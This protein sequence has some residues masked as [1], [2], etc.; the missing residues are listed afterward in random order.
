MEKLNDDVNFLY[1]VFVEP[2]VIEVERV[3]VF[4]Q[5][6]KADPEQ[7][8]KELDLLHR[9][10]K[11]RVKDSFGQVLA[12]SRVDFGG[13]FT[14]E[15][16]RLVRET[17]QKEKRSGEA[18]QEKIEDYLKPRALAFLQTLLVQLEKR[19]P[20][21]Q[22][23]F[24]GLSLLNPQKVLS[25][26]GRATF[27]ELPLR[28]LIDDMGAV[29]T[30]YRKIQ[31]QIWR[32]EAVFNGDLPKESEPFWAKIRKHQL[33]DGSFPYR[34]LSN[35]ALAALS[36]PV[37]NAIVERVFSHVTFVKNKNRSRLNL[38]MLDS[39]IRV[40]LSLRLKGICCTGLT[41]TPAM[42]NK[43]NITMYK[44][45]NNVDDDENDADVVEEL[46]VVDDLQ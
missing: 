20:P 27:Q 34:E 44:K 6:L 39:I 7:M 14:T 15:C 23:Q 12:L 46:Y 9:S 29:D 1:F 32:E 36:V 41:V 4:F 42:L 31:L 22:K 24:N 5:T 35:Y 26:S 28:H 19:L 25:Q 38:P 18:L 10:I 17:G 37:S 8:C 30:Q 3:N 43:F 33:S 16:M 40:R 45:C 13:V 2:I 21:S 11:V